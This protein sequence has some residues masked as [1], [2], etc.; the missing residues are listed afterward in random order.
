[1]HRDLEQRYIVSLYMRCSPLLQKTNATRRFCQ[2][3]CRIKLWISAPGNPNYSWS[4]LWDTHIQLSHLQQSLRCARTSIPS[5]I[6]PASYSTYSA[7]QVG[8]KREI[9]NNFKCYKSKR[10]NEAT[11][12]TGCETS[13]KCISV[14]FRTAS[15]TLWH[16]DPFYR[17]LVCSS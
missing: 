11:K 10:R 6:S 3:H 2:N 12:S 14:R 7:Q 13:G 8:E 4:T 16:T 1:M 9:S 5:S 17:G 15:Y